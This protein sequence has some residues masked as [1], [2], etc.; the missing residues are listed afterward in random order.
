MNNGKAVAIF[1]EINSGSYED[2]EKLIA[3]GQVLNMDTHNSISKN[4]ILNVLKWF[5][6]EFTEWE[7]F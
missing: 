2:D 6:E 7:E 5:Y 4:E 3:I 1:K